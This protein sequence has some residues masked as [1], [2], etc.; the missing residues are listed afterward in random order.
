ML[1][2]LLRVTRARCWA[3][4]YILN[5]LFVDA[6]VLEIGEGTLYVAQHVRL[7]VDVQHLQTVRMSA[8]APRSR[9][10]VALVGNFRWRDT[11]APRACCARGGACSEHPACPARSGVH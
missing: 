7:A 5:A 10:S 8:D 4:A 1:P 2:P 9:L 6:R 11:P 3:A